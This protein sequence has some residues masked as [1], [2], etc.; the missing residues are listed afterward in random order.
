VRFEPLTRAHD[1]TS[2]SSG[3]EVLGRWFRTQAGQ[4]ERRGVTRVF[5]AV[6]DA[7]IAGFYT[8][9]MYSVTSGD[10]PPAVIHRLPRYPDVPA[11]LIGRLARA[12]RVRG[13]GVGEL[14]VVDALGRALSAGRDLAAFAIVVDAK[15]ARAHSFYASF[16]FKSFP[17]RPSRM[18]LPAATAAALLASRAP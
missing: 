14:L 9:S 18:F 10:L 15:D 2:F 12:E 6:D 1:R 4:E 17:S 8:L 7:G 11:A 16:G 3:S 13:R 5:V